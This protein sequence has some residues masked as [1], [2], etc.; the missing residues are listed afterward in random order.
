MTKK[1]LMS[2]L[3]MSVGLALSPAHAA[4]ELILIKNVNVFD[5]I[6]DK[7][8]ENKDVLIEDNIIKMVATGI[9]VPENT[10]V[11]DGAGRTMTPGFIDAHTHLYWNT[12]VAEMLYSPADYHSIM[13]LSEAESTLMRGYTTIRDIAGSVFGIRKAIDQGLYPG[14]RIYTSGAAVGMTAGHGDM[15]SPFV[16]P[17]QFGG[18]AMTEFETLGFTKF[19]DGV[20]EVLG[21]ARVEMRKGADFLKMFVGGAVTGL[22]DPLDIAEYSE[23][24][25]KAFV[26]EADR[27]NTYAAVHTYTDKSTQAAIR[28]GAKSLEHNNLISEETIKMA[29]KND[30]MI[31]AQTALFMGEMPAGF[32]PAQVA[33]QQQAK[34]GLDNMMKL[35]KK[36]NAKILFG[37]DMVGSRD[38]KAQHV[39]EFVYRTKWFTSAE[40]LKQATSINAQALELTGPRNPYPKA[41]LGVIQEGA[42]ADILLHNNNPLEDITVL[43][44]PEE[45]LALIMKD[46][47]IFKN[48]IK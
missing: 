35:A 16:E 21:A 14:P 48:T 23:E 28:A 9:V 33:R 17:R 31:S 1:I 30:V 12:S 13:A 3:A 11:I 4:D 29:V 7:L 8:Q 43:T 32:S 42:Y 38:F 25:I 47:E 37:S 19:A 34:D 15:R 27:W 26:S 22:Y 45:N 6:Q 40:V 10:M 20:P 39:N 46:G 5:G 18:P 2:T 24:E 41:K 44:K 36:H